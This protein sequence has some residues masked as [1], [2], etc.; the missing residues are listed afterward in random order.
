[1]YLSDL[2]PDHPDLKANAKKTVIGVSADSRSIKAGMVFVAIK[3]AV[4]DGHDYI[5]DAIKAGAIAI[6]AAAPPPL[7]MKTDKIPLILTANPRLSLSKISAQ[8]AGRQPMVINAITGTNGKTSVAEFLRQIWQFTG[9]HSASLGTLGVRGGTKGGGGL[10]QIANLSTL[11]TPDAPSL[12]NS[13]ASM[14]AAD[15]T[16]LAIEASSH[17]IEQ[18][19]LSGLRLTAAG[20][21][22]LS[23]DHLDH[24][25]DME[26]YFLA[27]ARLFTE[28]LPDG[29]MAVININ[30]DY[31]KRLATMLKPRDIGVLTVGGVE[32]NADLQIK[33]ITPYDGGLNITTSFDGIT[34]VTPIGLMAAFQAENA[35]MAAALAH[36]SGLS[37]AHALLTLPYLTA[38]TGRMQTIPGLK[39]GGTVIV[40]F[41][42]TPD[43]LAVALASLRRGASG[44]LGVVFGCGGERDNGKRAEMGAIAAIHADFTIITDDNP[45]NEDPAAIRRM[46]LS[47][48]KN[49]EEIADRH[50]AI[51]AGIN[52]LGDGD[53]LLIAGKGH[54]S[55]QLIGSES[56]PFSDATEAA[57]IIANINGQ[58]GA[59]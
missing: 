46:I 42:H 3:G 8:L 36:V 58:R 28:L 59:I 1:M 30:D 9:W 23:R 25:V 7:K 51:T 12:H 10:D 26:H 49:A 50:K 47:T 45:R 57:A 34:R 2:F 16:N 22:N 14:V 38:A 6:V 18:E 43:A 15:I 39:N 5:D 4:F 24:H 41:A 37:M 52:R 40:D 21:T 29:A 13:L 17:G 32:E 56:L 55:N 31:G 48:A 44:H 27:K 53:I 35:V 33:A 11:T 54:E 20:F 19:R